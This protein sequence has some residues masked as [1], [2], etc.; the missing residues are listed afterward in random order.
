MI[1]DATRAGLSPARQQLLEIMQGLNFGRIE[2]L[3]IRGG[4]PCYEQP[5]RIVEE[6]KLSD[7][8]QMTD[9]RDNHIKFKREF[10]DLFAHLERLNEGVIDI[11][12]RHSVPFRLL[13]DRSHER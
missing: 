4:E 13:I 9:S 2:R 8:K 12:M 5:P 11:E 1:S 3:S 6:I 10:E 7:S